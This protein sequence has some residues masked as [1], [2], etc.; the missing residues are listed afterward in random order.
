MPF[1]GR[2]TVTL[3]EPIVPKGVTVEVELEREPHD[4][5][6]DGYNVKRIIR[7]TLGRAVRSAIKKGIR[8]GEK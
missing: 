3:E 4:D 2:L 7:R 1:N 6:D 8:R 5:S